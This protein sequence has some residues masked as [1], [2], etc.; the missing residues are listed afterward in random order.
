MIIVD[1]YF[2]CKE[3]NDLLIFDFADKNVEKIGLKLN[4]LKNF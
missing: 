2:H 4:L 3:Y 1:Q